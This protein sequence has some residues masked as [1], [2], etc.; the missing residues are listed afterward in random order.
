MG[1]R[2]FTTARLFSGLWALYILIHQLKQI[3]WGPHYSVALMVLAVVMSGLAFAVLCRP[4]HTGLFLTLITVQLAGVVAELPV[5]SN[6]W[7]FT[8]FLDVGILG[9]A[10]VT[11]RGGVGHCRL[12]E[13]YRVLAPLLRVSLVAIYAFAVVAK[14]NSD[15]LDPEVSCAAYLYRVMASTEAYL[16]SSVLMERA[17]V[18]MSLLAETS[19]PLLFVF[20]RTRSYAIV[21]GMLFHTFL[22]ASPLINVFDFNALLFTLYVAMAPENF[23]ETLIRHP[24]SRFAIW[25]AEQRVLVFGLLAI[26]SLLVVTLSLSTGDLVPLKVY[27]SYLWLLLGLGMTATSAA[28]LFT[29]DRE[30]APLVSPFRLRSAWLV[31]GLLLILVNGASPYLGLKTGVVYTMYSNLRTEDGF[32]NH[33]FIP[34]AL[35]VFSFQDAPVQVLESTAQELQR[36][37]DRN[38]ALVFFDFQGRAY[39]N[40]EASVRYRHHGT[41]VDV[42]RIGDDSTLGSPPDRLLSKLLYFRPIETGDRTCQW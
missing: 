41:V 17:A 29:P 15:F 8:G 26:L 7:L 35:R 19:L 4:G 9:A 24:A 32:E 40:A 20:R 25:V 10:I 38:E 27:R 18:P 14:F 13:I 12:E 1:E 28:V 6:V 11:T 33:L 31:P 23:S 3:P 16:P 39:R 42:A 21:A 36:V 30:L 34:K 5:M 2:K 37:S 22:A